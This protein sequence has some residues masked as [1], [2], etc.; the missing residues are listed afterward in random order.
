MKLAQ[1]FTINYNYKIHFTRGLFNEDNFLLMKILGKNARVMVFIDSGFADTNPAV[2]DQLI[3]WFPNHPEVTLLGAI[4]IVFGGEQIKQNFNYIKAMSK[5]MLDAKVCRH[6]YILIIGGGAVLDAV[7]FVASIFHRGVNYIRIPTTTL[8][9]ADSGVGVKNGVN[10]FDIKNLFGTFSPPYAVINDLLYLE[11]LS[12]KDALSGLSEAFKVAIIKSP[13]FYEQLKNCADEIK[14]MNLDIVEKVVMNCT[15][16]HH[17]HI[18]S[19]KDPFERGNTRPLDY[20]HWVAHRLEQMSKN[21]IRHGEAVA[22]GIVFDSYCAVELDILPKKIADDIYDTM[23]KAGFTLYYDVMIK[24]DTKGELALLDGLDE[25]REHL[26]GELTLV[27]P[28]EIGKTITINNLPKNI[29]VKVLKCLKK[30]SNQ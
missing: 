12:Y 5:K 10:L 18:A 17:Q 9:Q 24:K 4:E 1:T 11:S 2:L 28:T 22:V 19:S 27:M 15:K 20:G 21:K 16:I 29:I 25:F 6:S 23:Q 26:G 30:K 7:G 13:K 3:K 8:S 14:D